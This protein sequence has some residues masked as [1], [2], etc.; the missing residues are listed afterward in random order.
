MVAA[1][2]AYTLVSKAGD[3]AMRDRLGKAFAEFGVPIGSHAESGFR[4]PG[5][6]DIMDVEIAKILA[7]EAPAWAYGDDAKPL[8]VGPIND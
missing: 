5:I 1:K 6:A 4:M 8:D 2:T 3:N 7:K